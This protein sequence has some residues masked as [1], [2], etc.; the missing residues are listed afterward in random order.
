MPAPFRL[1]SAKGAVELARRRQKPIM[2]KDDG[3]PARRASAT[4]S[5]ERRHARWPGLGAYHQ[6]PAK[7]RRT[8]NAEIVSAERADSAGAAR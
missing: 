8:L 6:A 3:I 4:D 2:A 5:H 1:N 7:A